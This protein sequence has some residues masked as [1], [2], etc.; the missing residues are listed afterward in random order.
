MKKIV[1]MLLAAAFFITPLS[2]LGP[3][4]IQ[5]KEDVQKPKEVKLDDQQQKQLAILYEGLINKKKGIVNRY[6]EYGV[7]SKEK[8]EMIKKHLDKYYQKLK[9]NNFLP[10]NKHKEHGKHDKKMPK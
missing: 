3:M 2:G 4:N 10:L 5:A 6:V 9:E 8:G 7:Y 1:T